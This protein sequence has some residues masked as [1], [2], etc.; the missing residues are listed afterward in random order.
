MKNSRLRWL[1]AAFVFGLVHPALAQRVN[2]PSVDTSYTSCDLRMVDR[3]T[4]T[5][6]KVDS[7]L[8][9]V[10]PL[11]AG[12]YLEFL[13]DSM[14]SDASRWISVHAGETATSPVLG[15]YRASQSGRVGT[16]VAGQ[17]LTIRMAIPATKGSTMG[18]F[19]VRCLD[20]AYPQII[21]S[22]RVVPRGD[23]GIALSWSPSPT[24]SPTYL[25][26]RGGTVVDSTTDTSYLDDFTTRQA[27][28]YSITTRKDSL[29]IKG[30]S[31]TV[32]GGTFWARHG[33]DETTCKSELGLYSD[34]GAGRRVNRALNDEVVV[35]RPARP[36]EKLSATVA[37][38]L[39]T[40]TTPT[41]VRVFDGPDTSVFLKTI[42]D[43][44]DLRG[45]VSRHATGALT[46]VFKALDYD[47]Q[48][49]IRLSI[50]CGPPA[51]SPQARMVDEGVV[52]MTWSDNAMG[53]FPVEIQWGWGGLDSPRPWAVDT[54]PAG[55]TK[56][57]GSVGIT[58]PTLEYR[59]RYLDGSVVGPTGGYRVGSHQSY[60]RTDSIVRSCGFSIGG[61]PLSESG[62]LL[63]PK[64][65]TDSLRLFLVSVGT[66]SGD[67][68]EF[69]HEDSAR[70][71]DT[72]TFRSSD[73][74][75]LKGAGPGRGIRVSRRGLG[76]STLIANM[77]CTDTYLDKVGWGNRMA[78]STSPTVVF[79]PTYRGTMV[80][81]TSRN[82]F[83]GYRAV[84]TLEITDTTRS[85]TWVPEQA[86]SESLWVNSRLLSNGT[87][88]YFASPALLLPTNTSI[89]PKVQTAG[90]PFWSGRVLILPRE[91]PVRFVDAHGK[92]LA[93]TS[94]SRVSAPN[95]SSI[96]LWAVSPW[97][98]HRVPPSMVPASR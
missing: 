70:P 94:G 91:A 5:S 41:Q 54:V 12:K 27:V 84:D 4:Q 75:T 68:V 93:T 7:L 36:G 88:S 62:T 55:I 44:T 97:G 6:G 73:R 31:S 92:I 21:P 47:F 40:S 16:V 50:L 18:S 13:P 90:R 78:G 45:V 37:K 87:W 72:Y 14:N 11:D 60:G 56:W 32:E 9:V 86:P 8:Y 22:L 35:L 81:Y 83:E 24:T 71:F 79:S 2:L 51:V 77:G 74:I 63:R 10:R 85:T 57:R 23:N 80:V 39:H 49:T 26:V 19:R 3:F 1:A 42:S 89:Q 30:P 28:E 66:V 17:A 34:Y 29:S 61:H 20:Q 25:V 15:W 38:Y 65:P 33:L 69:F 59:A 96:P 48:S 53:K 58:G 76:N 95:S 64:S 43:S 98:T 82:A 46:F 52:E 67:T